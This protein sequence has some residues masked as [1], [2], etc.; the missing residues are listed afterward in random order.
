MNRFHRVVATVASG[1]L[2]ASPAQATGGGPTVPATT[3]ASVLE[4]NARAAQLIVGPGGAAKVPPLGL[5]DL[6]IVH[7]AIYDAVNAVEGFPFRSYAVVP[8]VAG[9]AS[10]DAAVAAA[11]RATLIALFPA[12]SADIETWYAASL[13]AIPDGEEEENGISVGEATAAGILARRASDGRNA[14][15]PIVEPPAATG[16]WVRT[17]P[18]L[19]APQAPWARSITPWLMSYPSQ[20]RPGPPPRLRSRTYRTDYEETRDL[21]GA[22]GGF[23]TD[24]QKDVGR[25]WAD[26]PML[27]WNRSWRGIARAQG[28]SGMDAARFFAMLSTAGSDALIACWDAKYEYFF[29][30]P[31]TSIRAGGG[32]P[33]L[34]GDAEWMSLVTTPNHPEYPAGHGCLSGASTSTLKRFFHD[35]AVAFTIDSTIAGVTTPV[36]TYSSFSEAL[37]EVVDARVYGGMHYRFTGEV[38]ARIGGKVA[39]LAARTFRPARGHHHGP[40]GHDDH[41]CDDRDD[42]VS[43]RDR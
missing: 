10:G 8:N 4:W 27:Q 39:R 3:A 15:T 11:G 21:G 28:L 23:A 25:F 43:D 1:V 13:A 35:D 6:A 26:S 14:G 29:W 36:R 16:V 24:G 42:A 17:P 2:L 32:D 12:R 40:H 41:E 19:A 5:V 20:F 37:D 34:T 7:T 22:V 30:R 31:V 9:P 38:G 33:R 18:A